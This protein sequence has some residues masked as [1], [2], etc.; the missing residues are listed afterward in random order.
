VH[1]LVERAVGDRNLL[2]SAHLAAAA[3]HLQH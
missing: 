1:A 2:A 3:R